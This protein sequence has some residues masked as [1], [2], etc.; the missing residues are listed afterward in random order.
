[1]GFDCMI[2]AYKSYDPNIKDDVTDGLCKKMEREWTAWLATQFLIRD[3]EMGWQAFIL[4][5]V[6]VTS[7]QRLQKRDFFYTRVAPRDLL[8]LLST[9]NGG[10][11]LADVVAL[12]TTM[13]LWLAEYPC[14]P[15]FINIFNDTQNKATIASFPIT[16]DWLASMATSALLSGNSFPNDCPAWDGLEPSAQSWTAWKLKFIPLHIAIER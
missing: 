8:N 16:D 15:K 14:V 12:F 1:M 9:Q 13:H 10:I 6:E 7:V 2:G 5:V 3:C 4:K 11:K